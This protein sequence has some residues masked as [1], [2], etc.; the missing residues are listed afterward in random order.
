MYKFCREIIA[1]F[2]KNYLHT[3]NAEDTTQILTHN[4]DRGF[5]RML[6]SID[7]MQ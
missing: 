3:T 6:G 2:E 1:V 7:C 4:A 5:P